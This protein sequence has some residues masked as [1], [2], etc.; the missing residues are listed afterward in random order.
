MFLAMNISLPVFEKLVGVA[1]NSE[2]KPLIKSE[3]RKF[4]EPTLKDANIFVRVN[5]RKNIR[6]L[7]SWFRN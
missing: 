7:P 3:N 5:P 4:L 6:Y 1:R 2:L